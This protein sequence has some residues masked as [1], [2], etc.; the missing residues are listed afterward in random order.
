VGPLFEKDSSSGLEKNNKIHPKIPVAD[1]PN[2]KLY[3]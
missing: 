1:I 2:I 3:S